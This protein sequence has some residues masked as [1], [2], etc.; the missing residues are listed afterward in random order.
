[1]SG[2]TKE[3]FGGDF[4]TPEQEVPPEG[5]P[6][7]DW[8]T[9]MTMND[10]WGF[11]S[12]DDDWKDTRTL[13]RTL[14][15]VASKGG[16]FL[17]NVGPTAEGLI[18]A[19][20]VWRLREMGD[21]MK[22]NGEAIYGTAVSPY[23]MPRWGRYTAKRGRVYAHVFDWP[24]D[25]RLALTGVKEKPLRAYLLADGTS[26]TID[27][28]DSGFAVSVPAV[29][30][31]T[32]A[33]V[34]VLEVGGGSG[35]SGGSNLHNLPVKAAVLYDVGRIAVREV[36]CPEPP[37]RE[38]RV[39]VTA[40]G[41][42]GT[43][44]H[45]FAGHANYNRD[46]RGRPIPLTE[47]PQILGHEIAGVVEAVGAGVDGLRSGDRVVIDQG[48]NCVSEARSPVCEYCA[49]G[50][51]H[52]CEFYREHGI[53]GVPG[54]LAEYLTIPAVNAVR[55]ESELDAASAALTE[56][57]GC[58]VHS[59]DVLIHTP[60]RYALHDGPRRGAQIS[61]ALICGAGPAGLLWVQY[62]RNVLGYD[63]LLLV[64]EPNAAKRALA[65]QFG[66]ETIDPAAAD[67]VEAV[68]ERT[69]GRR[70]ELLIEATGSG[71]VVASIPGLVRKQATV[72][73]YG[74]GHA[75]V[76]LS[77]MNPLQFME[78]TLLAPVGASGGFESDGRPSTYVRAL[79]LIE[80]GQVD[81]ESLITHY[82]GSLDSVACA[83][84]DDH[85]APD[86]VKGVAT[87]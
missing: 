6:G 62:L 41:L 8:E 75:G 57:L 25:G 31:S 21:W 37:P 55:I 69:C 50:H 80:R 51:S 30:P 58:V 54:G 67:V 47:Q 29:P 70:I 18:P 82:Y 63:G 17:L 87:L 65:A 26:L 81:V 40:V 77:V 15:D 49:D 34:L 28:T 14:I 36:P 16:N 78:P 38:V 13:V 1:M 83:F 20:S 79:R 2:F 24:K 73:L 7:V 43:D 27:S 46:E 66:A 19:P 3:G 23:G 85:R 53:T 48:R 12:Y 71:H 22:A 59:S 74:H 44:L 11:K 32:I 68:R 60:A 45:I 76:D 52:Q 39:R 9:C 72:L 35:G 86:Y 61:C 5:L 84:T 33:T 64:S 4:G 10:T 42:C 56:P